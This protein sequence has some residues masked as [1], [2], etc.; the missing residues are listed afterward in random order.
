MKSV[1]KR[2]MV[3]I[4]AGILAMP[5]FAEELTENDVISGTMNIAFKTRVSRDKSGKFADGSPVLGVKD[6][7]KIDVRV[8]KTTEFSG[9]V[10]RQPKV[11][12][13]LIGVEAQPAM[14]QYDLSASVLNPSNLSQ[15]KTVGKWVGIAPMDTANNTFNF[16][17][18]KDN[19]LRMTI[20]TIGNA[21]GFTDKF[22]GSL[23]GKQDKGEGW[24]EK[25]TSFTFERVIGKKKVKLEAKKVEPLQFKE[26]ELAKGPSSI[27]PHTVVN[28][29]MNFDYQTGNWYIDNLHFKYN[30]DGK[31]VEDV[32]SGTIKWVEDSQRAT[33]GKGKYDFNVRFNED[34]FAAQTSEADAFGNMNDEEAFFAVDNRVPALN[35]QVDYLDTMVAGS[36]APTASQITYRLNANK[37][38]KQQ[39]MNFFKLWMLAIGPIND[40]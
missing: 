30:L 17:A 14:L 28:G 6:E 35:G 25:L 39:I 9:T 2:W 8:A 5:V 37:L 22:G 1:T 11:K 15:K 31:E 27:Y 34:K 40:E 7:Y 33:N 19:E 36:E 26:V 12:V 24:Q 3:V 21:Q 10:L 18:S 29:R 38:T 4:I 16:S 32:V 23:V 20:D 13:K